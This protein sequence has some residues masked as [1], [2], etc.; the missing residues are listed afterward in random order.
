MNAN[1]GRPETVINWPDESFTAKNIKQITGL[2][3]VSVYNRI[4]KA[5]KKKLI[6][7]N[8]RKMLPNGRPE[9][10]FRKTQV[11]AAQNVNPPQEPAQTTV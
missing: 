1:K 11:A 3:E 9:N 4:K 2:S 5:L 6:E 8:G 10:L 7:K